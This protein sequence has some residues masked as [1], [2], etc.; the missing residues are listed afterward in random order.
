LV[1]SERLVFLEAVIR[2]ETKRKVHQFT[3]F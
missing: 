1:Y 2:I 3:P